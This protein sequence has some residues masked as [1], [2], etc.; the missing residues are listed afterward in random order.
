MLQ[1]LSLGWNILVAAGLF[2]LILYLSPAPDIGTPDGLP[3]VDD[4]YPTWTKAFY[5]GM[6]NDKPQLKDY[7][8]AVGPQFVSLARVEP[9]PVLFGVPVAAQLPGDV[10][11]ID[12]TKPY[13]VQEGTVQPLGDKIAVYVPPVAI[14]ELLKRRAALRSLITGPAWWESLLSLVKLG[15]LGEPPQPVDGRPCSAT[16]WTHCKGS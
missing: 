14:K 15:P 10:S 16:G 7:F 11:G 5:A 3:S 9:A 8:L 12:W 6:L 2:V 13:E 4:S 1:K